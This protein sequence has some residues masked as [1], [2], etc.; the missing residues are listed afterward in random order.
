MKAFMPEVVEVP[1][2][3]N[4]AAQKVIEVKQGIKKL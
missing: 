1:N 3:H 2:P 4:G